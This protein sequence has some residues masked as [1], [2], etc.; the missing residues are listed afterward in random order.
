[1]RRLRRMTQSR[2]WR[3][4]SSILLLS[5]FLLLCQLVFFQQAVSADDC[6]RDWRRAE[7]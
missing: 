3:R 1:M 7:D 2:R 4:A 6:E 5:S